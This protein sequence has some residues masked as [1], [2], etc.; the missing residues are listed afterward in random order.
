MDYERGHI[1]KVSIS[2]VQKEGEELELLH[3]EWSRT[4]VS[5]AKKKKK[6]LWKNPSSRQLP[7][8]IDVLIQDV[9]DHKFK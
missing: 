3:W 9:E 7:E 8:V 6:Y 1:L 2:D 4:F 5:S